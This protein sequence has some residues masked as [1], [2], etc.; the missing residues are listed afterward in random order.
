MAKNLVDRF[1][2]TYFSQDESMLR[3]NDPWRG[4]RTASSDAR[5]SHQ[6]SRTISQSNFSVNFQWVWLLS[7]SFN[8]YFLLESYIMVSKRHFRPRNIV[9]SI[10]EFNRY[11]RQMVRVI[12]SFSLLY[13]SQIMPIIAQ[14]TEP[15]MNA[16]IRDFS[17]YIGSGKKR[18]LFGVS[19]IF[20]K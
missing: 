7:L 4:K 8:R 5:A 12:L 17:L 1:S 10:H 13:F 2:V 20:L 9:C 18:P 19:D 15:F 16:H 3:L 11:R 6:V 14:S